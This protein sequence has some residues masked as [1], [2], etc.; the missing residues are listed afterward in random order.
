MEPSSTRNRGSGRRLDAFAAALLSEWRRLKLPLLDEIAIVAVSG[1]PDSTALLLALVEL[2]NRNKLGVKLV[3]AHLDHR[4]R[5][6]SK[7][8]ATG[9][10]RLA[11]SI[12][13]E[14]IVGRA[15][16][17]K[18]ASEAADNLEQAARRARYTFLEKTAKRKKAKLILVAHTMDDQAETVLLRLVRGSASEGLSG[19]EPVRP[20]R[21]GSNIRIVRPLLSWARRLD[22]ESYCRRQGA[23][24]AVDEM[25]FDEKFTRVKVRRQLLPLMESFNNRIVETLFRTASLLREDN[26]TLALNASELLK[27]AAEAA[28]SNH[29]TSPPALDVNVLAKA[30]AALRRRALRQWLA[31]GR[32]GLQRVERV[33]LLGV[34]RLLE[35]AKGGRIA[36]LPGGATVRRV[37]GRLEL[38]VKRV[39]KGSGNL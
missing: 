10:S 27:A 21:E 33:H 13:V 25:N 23:A 36:E 19:M 6:A 35:G 1:G 22:T 26:T 30:P 20:L 2:M 34:E 11:K 12:G 14:A 5:K 4:L 32:G 29:E 15:D 39:E 3:V 38:K 37:R 7:L 24:Y 8:D 16:V 17:K 18:L 28:D 31:E 9:V